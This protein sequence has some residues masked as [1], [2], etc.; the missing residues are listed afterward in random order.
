MTVLLPIV[1]LYAMVV[2]VLVDP[3][4]MEMH[5]QRRGHAG[6]DEMT[7]HRMSGSLVKDSTV[8]MRHN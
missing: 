1:P 7:S 2:T 5:N 6:N 3:L 8:D 4:F